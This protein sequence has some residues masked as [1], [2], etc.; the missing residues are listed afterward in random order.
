MLYI[1][2]KTL[3]ENLDPYKYNMLKKRILSASILF[4][5]FL[6]AFLFKSPIIFFTLVFFSSLI[7]LN[8]LSRLLKLKSLSLVVYWVLSISPI[9]FFYFFYI[10]INFLPNT[11]QDLFKIFLKDFTIGISFIGTIFW[12]TLVPLDI[13]YKK[14]SS[15]SKFKIFF[16][17]FI[18]TPMILVSLFMFIEDKSF[19][20]ILFFMIWF[21]DIGAYVCGKA[22]GKNKLAKNISPGKT[23]EGAIGGFLSNVIF[24]F[25]LSQFY[26]L[27]LLTLL[28]F[29]TLVTG[30]S[31]YGDI[32]Q[33]FL[34]RRINVKDSGSIIPGHGGL[35]DRL[36]SFCPTIPIS[37]LVLINCNIILPKMII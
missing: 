17:Y 19:I 6:S 15:N 24:V 5:I 35:F 27:N 34:K 22:F 31:I 36:D 18:F 30:L 2:F 20:L 4:F 25:I 1:F 23:I 16:G 33:S 11:N 13:F 14:I 12:L 9:I 37:Y 32:Y 26:V 7:L 10:G 21:A 28:A 8:E 29:A 3:K